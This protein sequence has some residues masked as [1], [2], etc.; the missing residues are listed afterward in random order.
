MSVESTATSSASQMPAF[1]NRLD[2]YLQPSKPLQPSLSHNDH[3]PPARHSINVT[4]RDH[5]HNQQQQQQQQQQNG[6]RPRTM[7]ASE[8]ASAD[9]VGELTTVPSYSNR[10]LHK[11]D[12]RSSD[13]KGASE[14]HDTSAV[15][16]RNSSP[17]V[18]LNALFSH[19]FR[20]TKHHHKASTKEEGN[21]N[22]MTSNN[23]NASNIAPSTHVNDV[24]A[25]KTDAFST[26]KMPPTVAN[27]LRLVNS[28]SN[29]RLSSNQPED[30]PVQS[31]FTMDAW[32]S[33]P[34]TAEP[35]RHDSN[36]PPC[37]AEN[38]RAHF[39]DYFHV[40]YCG[41]F[42]HEGPF[43]ASLRVMHQKLPAPDNSEARAI[44]RT[45][46]RNYV[47]SEPLNEANEQHIL[48]VLFDKIN[49]SSVRTYGTIGD[50]KTNEKV[51]AFDKINDERYNC[52]I[53]VLYQSSNQVNELQILGNDSLTDELRVFLES[54]SKPVSLKGFP[55]YRGD[56]DTKDDLHGEYSYYTVHE[57]HEIMFNVA[58]IVPSTK[59]NGQYIERKGLIGNAFVCIIFQE[60]DAI[61]SPDF[62]S[63]KV[64]QIYISVQ[65]VTIENQLYYKICIWR[66]ND[67]TAQIW[68]PGGVYKFDQSFVSFFLTLLLNAI[69][70]AVES[71]S[72]RRQISEQRQRLKCE[73]LRK[74]A[75]MFSVG[76]IPD[77]HIEYDYSQ[78]WV[79]ARPNARSESFAGTSSTGTNETTS[80]VSGRSSPV[81]KKRGFSKKLLGVFSGRSGSVTSASSNY[82]NS[83]TSSANSQPSASDASTALGRTVSHSTK[84]PVKRAPSVKLNQ[85]PA[86]PPRPT[87]SLTF[88]NIVVQPA[89]P[90][91]APANP[92]PSDK[93]QSS[94]ASTI[95]EESRSANITDEETDDDDDGDEFKNNSNDDDNSSNPPV[96]SSS[97]MNMS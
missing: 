22:P 18:Y 62:I 91:G 78:H 47:I 70:V 44:V 16:R 76:P 53:G 90:S 52:K 82:T 86:A 95:D 84:E 7:S 35:F 27:G 1:K 57:N 85:A 28:Q 23:V 24:T 40:N 63:G 20:N 3:L 61:F 72:L 88:Q 67:I 89:T 19:G 17:Q 75:H 92:F 58:P 94:H 80:T 69:N 8:E 65:P 34:R 66:R 79:E 6:S 4:T 83:D 68:P 51:Y 81:P 73:E 45:P 33:E 25:I 36:T 21:N 60:P 42:E 77:M 11:R 55:N 2:V 29:D 71:P 50:P 49:F 54:I 31:L 10:H 9:T 74:L 14:H 30:V 13:M 43:L 46:V 26:S 37:V 5:H 64:T 32:T 56:L 15:D 59:T 97:I 39:Y 12:R 96:P 93:S 38:Y 87:S 48:Q 41:E